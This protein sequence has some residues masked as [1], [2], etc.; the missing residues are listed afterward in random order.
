MA[1]APFFK[2]GHA[3]S[4]VLGTSGNPTLHTK[5]V[6]YYRA[7]VR[8]VIIHRLEEVIEPLFIE[9]DRTA[10]ASCFFSGPASK[11]PTLSG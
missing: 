2:K 10:G 3:V 11:N 8:N 1:P 4:H 6:Y 5:F 9:I 7:S